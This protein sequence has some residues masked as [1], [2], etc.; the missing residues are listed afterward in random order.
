MPNGG[1][2]TFYDLSSFGIVWPP[3]PPATFYGDH[4]SNNCVSFASGSVTSYDIP[5]DDDDP[6]FE[7]EHWYGGSSDPTGQTYGAGTPLG[8][9]GDPIEGNG[10]YLGIT[11]TSPSGVVV[12]FNWVMVGGVGYLESE[13]VPP[14]FFDEVGDYKVQSTKYA[15]KQLYMACF[16][17]GTRL[18]TPTGQVAIEDICEGDLVTTFDDGPQKVRWIGSQTVAAEGRFAPIKIAKGTLGTTR[19]LYVSP[20]HRMLLT[21]W[22]AELLFGEDEILAT[23][24]SLINDKSIARHPGGRVEYFHVL[25]DKHQIVIAEGAPSESFYPGKPGLDALEQEMSDEIFELFPNLR[26]DH[27]AYGPLS[28][29]AVRGREVRVAFS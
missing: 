17:R 26:D 6:V 25:F 3:V 24:Q 29:A 20:L 21:G 23:A 22:Q 9:A 10:S 4:Y 18:L 2:L 28:R 14:G 27:G 19:D 13:E 16:A 15:Y 8:T 5:V 7:P 12:N 1:F 11:I